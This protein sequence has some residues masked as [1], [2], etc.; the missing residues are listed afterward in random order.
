MIGKEE[1]WKTRSLT[2]ISIHKCSICLRKKS[3]LA[4]ENQK[5]SFKD[6]CSPNK[7][8]SKICD[9]RQITTI[10]STLLD[11]QNSTGVI[12]LYLIMLASQGNRGTLQSM[13]PD[14][15]RA[16]ASTAAQL[17][18]FFYF[19]ELCVMHSSQAKADNS[20]QKMV[21]DMSPHFWTLHGK[22]SL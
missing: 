15:W 1:I 19:H 22:C 6:K 10:I 2:R 3:Q 16:V 11:L 20:P 5:K 18:F 14:W 17:I 21:C 13:P 8:A 9:F 4:N 12:N 7:C